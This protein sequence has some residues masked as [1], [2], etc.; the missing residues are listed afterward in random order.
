MEVSVCVKSR[1][2][3]RKKWR[4][5]SASFNMTDGPRLW[6]NINGWKRRVWTTVFAPVLVHE[7]H[8]YPRRTAFLLRSKRKIH[9]KKIKENP[10]NWWKCEM[11]TAVEDSSNWGCQSHRLAIMA[12][13]GWSIATGANRSAPISLWRGEPSD[14]TSMAT[15]EIEN[16]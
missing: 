16:L 8:A 6:I 2:E 14:R 11:A 10:D 4:C 7:D 5:P 3:R 1:G 9:S 13:S 12:M 15:I